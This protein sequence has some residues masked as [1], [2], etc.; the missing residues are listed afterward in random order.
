MISP[1][2]KKMETKNNMKLFS[3]SLQKVGQKNNGFF[4]VS[5]IDDNDAINYLRRNLCKDCSLFNKGKL[6]YKIN[7]LKTV[8]NKS[9]NQYHIGKCTCT[10]K[11]GSDKFL[12]SKVSI[13]ENGKDGL[14]F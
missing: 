2:E 1:M 3:V 10:I 14:M 11:F 5:G 4:I 7:E 9:D 6:L 12:N 13:Y 8:D